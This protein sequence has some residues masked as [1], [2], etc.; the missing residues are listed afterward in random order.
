ML[1]SR[2]DCREKGK[3]VERKEKYFC[4]VELIRIKIENKNLTSRFKFS[5]AW[6][7]FVTK[8]IEILIKFKNEIRKI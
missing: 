8:R 1:N 7:S 4:S 5:Y 2:L 3:I 6:N